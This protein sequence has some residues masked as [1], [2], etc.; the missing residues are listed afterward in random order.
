MKTSYFFKH[1]AGAF[2]F[3]LIL[4]LC[5]GRF[6]Y[7]QGIIYMIIGLMM[8]TLNYTL[9]RPDSEL[10]NERSKPGEGAK[11]WDK[12]LLGLSGLNTIA[13]FIIAGLDSGR[14]YWSPNFHWSLYLI[15]V[16]LTVSG[17]LLF[18]FAQ[19]QNK[20]FSSTVRIQTDREHTVCDTGLYNII[21]HPA[22]LGSIIQLTGFPLLFGSLWSIIPVSLLILLH[23]TRTYLE[24]KTLI[25]ELNGYLEYSK[26]TRY[27][28]VPYVW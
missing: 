21:R 11:K 19:K 1:F 4:F 12:I 3:F 2:I 5:A 9:L 16:F 26:K 14:Y 22:Y 23:L 20:F 8:F 6:D 10:L 18:L 7:W 25:K 28:I 15:G 27:K 24:D 13:M 17:Q